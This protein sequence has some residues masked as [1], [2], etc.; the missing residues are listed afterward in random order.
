MGDWR[1]RLQNCSNRSDVFIPVIAF[2]RKGLVFLNPE[3]FQNFQV[4]VI[5]VPR[6]GVRFQ[7]FEDFEGKGI[8]AKG[9]PVFLQWFILVAAHFQQEFVFVQHAVEVQRA[10][11]KSFSGFLVLDG[12]DSLGGNGVFIVFFDFLFVNHLRFSSHPTIRRLIALRA[13]GRRLR[14][15]EACGYGFRPHRGGRQGV[16]SSTSKIEITPT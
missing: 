1:L 7:C 16:F 10:S 13:T 6:I 5:I 12:E 11:Q 14:A 4:F 3:H 15:T 2:I 9:I 8:P